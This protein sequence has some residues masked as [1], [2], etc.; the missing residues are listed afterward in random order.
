MNSLDSDDEVFSFSS[1]IPVS[2]FSNKCDTR[3]KSFQLHMP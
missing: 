1:E 3:G 2:V